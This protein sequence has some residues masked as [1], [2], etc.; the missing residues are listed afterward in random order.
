MRPAHR[1]RD[2]LVAVGKDGLATI[3][4]IGTAP[5][6]VRL[7]CAAGVTDVEAFQALHLEQPRPCRSSSKCWVV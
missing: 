1:A 3:A 4:A 6:P 5:L 7:R 2:A